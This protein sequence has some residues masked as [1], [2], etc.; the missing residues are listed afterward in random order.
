MPFFSDKKVQSTLRQMVVQLPFSVGFIVIYVASAVFVLRY[1][2]HN[3]VVAIFWPPTGL[4]LAAVMIQGRIFLPVV[5]AGALL[6]NLISGVPLWPAIIFALGNALQAWLGH[7]ALNFR[8]DSSHTLSHARE[9]FLIVRR[10]VLVAP[11]PSAFIGAA[12]LHMFGLTRQDWL[13]NLEH[14]WMGD[15]LGVLVLTPL[16]LVWRR[17]PENWYSSRQWIE[18]I[19]GLALAALAGQIIFAGWFSEIF[20]DYAHGFVLFVFV[21]WAAVRFGRHATAVVIGLLVL[22]ILYGVLSQSGYFYRTGNAMPLTSIWLYIFILAFTGMALAIFVHERKNSLLGLTQAHERLEL[23]GSLAKIGAWDLDV[24]TGEMQLSREAR[25]IA[26]LP[27]ESPMHFQAAL[28]FLDEQEQHA[29]A[30]RVQQ[31]IEQGIGWDTEFAMVTH[32]GR[33]IWVRSQANPV[34]ENGRI[35]RLVGSMHDL[36]EKREKELALKKSELDFK[37]LVETSEEGIWTIDSEGKTTFVNERM[38]DILGYTQ[39]EMLGKPFTYFMTP[40]RAEAALALLQRRNEGIH[41]V[42]EFCL[43]DK[44]GRE[45]WTLSSTNAIRSEDGTVVGA[46]AMVTDITARKRIERDLQLSEERYRHLVESASDGII[47]HVGGFIAYANDAALRL[48]GAK[49]AEEIIGRNALEFVAPEYRQMVIERM[50]IV[51][52]PGGRAPAIEEKFMR[53]DGSTIDVEVSATGTRFNDSNATMVVVRD[54]SERKNAEEQIRY[55]G[56]HD[57]LTGLPNRALFADRLTQTISFAAAH[58]KSFALLFLDLDHFKKINDSHGHQIGDRFLRQVSGRLL[59]CV[60]P[61]DTASRQG[62]DEFSIIIAELEHADEAAFMARRICE[63]LSEPFQVEALRLHASASVGIAMY[64]KDGLQA[65]VL[66]RNADIA[67]YHA[68]G[69]GRNQFQFFSEELNRTTHERLEIEAA[70]DDALEKNEFEVYYQPQLNLATGKIESCEALIRWNHAKKGLLAPGEFISV[71]E[72]SG[73]IDAIG[74]WVL[75][76]VAADFAEFSAAGFS[77]MRLA[78][79][80]SSPQMRV[81]DFAAFVAAVVAEHKIP[82]GC[83]ELEVTESMLM[84]D[85]EQAIATISSLTAQGVRFS[86]DDFGT[87]Y[88][89]LSYLRSLKIHHLKIDRSF[90]ADVISDPDD[91]TIVRA[92]ISLAHSL[93]LTA[94]AEGVESEQQLQFLKDEGCD[95]VQGYL[96]ARPM[97]LADCIQFAKS[98][99][100]G[101]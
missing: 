92:I 88:S 38:A 86:I 98:Y 55:L 21:S 26:E 96:L 6:A 93:R 54:I 101:A 61:L 27:P 23:V 15:S 32:T 70:I 89:S 18:G 4:A 19:V 22:Q 31:A 78:V 51:N 48:V 41:E 28:T 57:L 20:S 16:L 14:W 13:T 76:R 68:K 52:A 34:K 43:Q 74:R 49:N 40:D 79:N 33:K 71:A 37:R 30:G 29:H 64:P 62:G 39:D 72:E 75:R 66:L 83:L 56:Q 63:A 91:A 81:I 77:N 65:E 73:H 7:F 90:V 8:A 85:T 69:S 95:M 36:T 35:V 59:E 45:V 47:V 97:P 58:K 44:G 99:G 25:R 87:G 10:A 9:Y 42:H 60:G 46:L 84:S 82:A 53:L 94:I 100:K 12:T 3:G 2:T 80:V 5:A 24:M 67:M 50:K 1:F 11:L 17:V